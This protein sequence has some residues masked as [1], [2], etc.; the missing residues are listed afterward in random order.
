MSESLKV[1][2]TE[3]CNQLD[4][5]MF[6]CWRQGLKHRDILEKAQELRANLTSE[7]VK[8]AFSRMFHRE[9]SPNA[10]YLKRT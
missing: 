2:N 1:F 9:L 5:L 4:R 3:F 7:E 6:D 8:E 10:K